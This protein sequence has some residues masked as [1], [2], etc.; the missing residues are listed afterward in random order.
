[1]DLSNYRQAIGGDIRRNAV[2]M[3]YDHTTGSWKPP[4]QLEGFI[5]S[6]KSVDNSTVQ[7][8][9]F[10][11]KAFGVRLGNF[12]STD[13]G[14]ANPLQFLVP[15]FDWNYY[16]EENQAGHVFLVDQFMTRNMFR[17][18]NKNDTVSGRVVVRVNIAEMRM[19]GPQELTLG[20]HGAVEWLI[21][22]PAEAKPSKRYGKM[23]RLIRRKGDK[24]IIEHRV[25]LEA[26][27]RSG[28]ASGLSTSHPHP[29]LV[30][31]YMRRTK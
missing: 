16:R 23:I 2:F 1:M 7:L 10:D 24:E 17:M 14:P 9:G 3:V 4:V 6:E 12:L 28:P 11:G 20:K 19:A 25:S 22:H 27:L 18:P 13:H 30:R 29:N 21:G 8:L 31:Y 15:R 5:P 26:L